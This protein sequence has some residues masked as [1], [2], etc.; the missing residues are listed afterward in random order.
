MKFDPDAWAPGR[1][2]VRRSIVPVN[3]LQTAQD[4][5]TGEGDRMWVC[6]VRDQTLEGGSLVVTSP[7][8]SVDND[9]MPARAD[10]AIVAS[11]SQ[12]NIGASE[13]LL[14][15]HLEGE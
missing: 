6:E 12:E 4:N 10:A 8:A 15:S 2:V 11:V 3:T 14:T 13:T 5:G 1:V 9:D 7:L